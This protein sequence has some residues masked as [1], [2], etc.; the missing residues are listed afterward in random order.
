MKQISVKIKLTVVYTFFTMCISI[1]ALAILLSISNNEILASLRQQLEER[2]KESFRYI[3]WED[4]S[5]DIDSELIHV[6]NNIY[7][8]VYN[9]EGNLI[10]GRIP[11]EFSQDI[12]IQSGKIRTFVVGGTKWYVF[13]NTSEIVGYQDV[14]I[15]GIVS[16]TNEENNFSILVKTSV[17]GMP[18]LIILTAIIGY[19]FTSRTLKP[20]DEMTKAVQA[21]CENE[22]LSKR[23]SIEA[24]KDEI[25]RL[26]MMLNQ[27]LTQLEEA[28]EREKR[29]TADV[30]HELR[31]PI[32]VMLFHCEALL[33]RETLSEEDRKEMEVIERKAKNMAQLVSQILL[34]SRADRE[35]LIL[36]KEW[37]D[38]SELTE[39]IVE[40]QEELA[41]KKKQT[42]QMN[43]QEGIKAFVDETFMIRLWVNLLSNAIAY[44]KEGGHIWIRLM[45]EGEYIV[46][47]VQDDGIGMNQEQMAHIWERFYRADQARTTGEE[48]SSGLGLPMVKWIVQAHKGKIDVVSEEGIGTTFTF[49]LPSGEQ[50]K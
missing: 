2:V 23:V 39:L 14:T 9:E 8:S 49:R 31:T 19:R 32:T 7:L 29:F 33:E 47:Q 16:A 37:I 4:G 21:I 12:P 3:E 28:F 48:T 5:L 27:M 22:D 26:G 45:K 46:G 1:A 38:L 24:G 17:I 11:Y 40:E 34:L 25:H 10:Y 41:Y 50:E 18:L 43:I 35:Q 13:D 30:S 36:N 20:V 42:I 15:R 44:G 6:E